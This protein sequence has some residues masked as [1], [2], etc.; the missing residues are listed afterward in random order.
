MVLAKLQINIIPPFRVAS[1]VQPEVRVLY[2]C[3]N[4]QKATLST[5][6]I[7]VEI[8]FFEFTIS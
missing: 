1:T 4:A 3:P 8:T 7:F 2:P 6:I 5:S